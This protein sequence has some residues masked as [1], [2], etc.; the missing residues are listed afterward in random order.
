MGSTRREL[1]EALFGLFQGPT[2]QPIIGRR[3]F[4]LGND[5]QLAQGPRPS[6]EARSQGGMALWWVQLVLRFDA[7]AFSEAG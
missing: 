5:W 3:C 7:N 6:F 1:T 4:C 2:A